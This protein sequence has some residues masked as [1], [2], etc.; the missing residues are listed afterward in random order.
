MLSDQIEL[1]KLSYGKL[2]KSIEPYNEKTDTYLRKYGGPMYANITI[3]DD[4][5]IIAFY[6]CTGMGDSNLTLHFNNPQSATIH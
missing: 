4:D 1:A 2:N 6:N 5:A 3:F